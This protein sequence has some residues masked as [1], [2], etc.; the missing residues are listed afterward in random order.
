MLVKQ[1]VALNYTMKRR[2]CAL[3]DR[4]CPAELIPQNIHTCVFFPTTNVHV[5]YSPAYI[6]QRV[7][8]KFTCTYLSP[9]H[10]CLGSVFFVV[11][12]FNLIACTSIH[13]ILKYKVHL[14]NLSLNRPEIQLQCCLRQCSQPHQLQG[15]MLL[16]LGEVS[17]GVRD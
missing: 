8:T 6:F 15:V 3:I 10:A 12:V 9:P 2:H 7:R 4:F 5:P 17:S 14:Q 16:H 11:I 13:L 1:P